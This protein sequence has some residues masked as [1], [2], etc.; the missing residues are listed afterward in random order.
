MGNDRLQRDQHSERRAMLMKNRHD[1][2]IPYPLPKETSK[3]QSV[4]M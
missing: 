4:V 3:N 1:R 2:E